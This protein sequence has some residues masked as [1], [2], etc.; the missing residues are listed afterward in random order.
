MAE[1]QLQIVYVHSLTDALHLGFINVMLYRDT[2]MIFSLFEIIFMQYT[3]I[4][5]SQN[6]EYDT[7][8]LN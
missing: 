7:Y 6:K 2:V 3:S 8:H 5:L 1:S 4:A